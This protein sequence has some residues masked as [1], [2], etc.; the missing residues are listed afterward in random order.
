MGPRH[1]SRVRIVSTGM[2][3]RAIAI[4]SLRARI[5]GE[6]S[7]LALPRDGVHDTGAGSVSGPARVPAPVSA[8]TLDK[9]HRVAEHPPPSAD[10]VPQAPGVRPAVRQRPRAYADIRPHTALDSAP[11]SQGHLCLVRR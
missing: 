7:G 6:R 9:R 3:D 8:N 10:A 11:L 4:V 2:T 1:T 5:R